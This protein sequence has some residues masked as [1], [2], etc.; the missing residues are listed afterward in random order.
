MTV[1]LATCFDSRL[2]FI[3]TSARY[4]DHLSSVESWDVPKEDIIVFLLQSDLVSK[5]FETSRVEVTF[6]L[7]QIAVPS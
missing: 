5:F 4:K 3:L 7:L 1:L 6:L 2:C